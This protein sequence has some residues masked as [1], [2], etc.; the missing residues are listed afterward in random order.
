MHAAMRTYKPQN[1]ENQSNKSNSK[2]TASNTFIGGMRLHKDIWE[3]Y[4]L[5]NSTKLWKG[6]KINVK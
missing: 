3:F 4:K 2:A 5:V 6:C 1:G